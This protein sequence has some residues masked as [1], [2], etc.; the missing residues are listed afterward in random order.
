MGFGVLEPHVFTKIINSACELSCLQDITF[1]VTDCKEL[2]KTVDR[3]NN[4]NSGVKFLRFR[5]KSDKIIV[6]SDG[7]FQIPACLKRGEPLKDFTV[8]FSKRLSPLDSAYFKE[9]KFKPF[10]QTDDG[11]YVNSKESVFTLPSPELSIAELY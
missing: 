4:P 7:G 9:Q 5:A 8:I 3:F 2:S 10:S 6:P 11:L 1:T